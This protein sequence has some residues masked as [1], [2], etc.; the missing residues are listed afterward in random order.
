MFGNRRGVIAGIVI[1]ILAIVI[2]VQMIGGPVM[3]AIFSTNNSTWDSGTR[4]IWLLSG[5]AAASYV[6]LLFFT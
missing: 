5:I 3:T 1:K 6:V 2:A 4:S